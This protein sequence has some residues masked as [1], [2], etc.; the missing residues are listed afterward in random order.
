M[1]HPQRRK[2]KAMADHTNSWFREKI[3]LGMTPR[4]YIISNFNFSNLIAA[5]FVGT[6]VAVMIY[7][8]FFGLGPATN[9]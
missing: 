1:K 3:L 8:L 5:I 6:G 4:D 7:R 2:E 9:L